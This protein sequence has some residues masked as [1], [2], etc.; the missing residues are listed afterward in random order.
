[1][2]I[3]IN[4]YYTK[5]G[6]NPYDQFEYEL[7]T[8]E[9]KNPDGT[10]VFRQENVEVPK[11]WSQVA[12]DILASKYFK[13]AG[14]PKIEKE[15][16][17]KQV[18]HRL[19][20]TWANW[21]E[22]MGYFTTEEDKQAFYD[23]IVYMLLAQIA[24]PNSPQFFNTGLYD[25]YGIKGQ[26]RGMW[27]VDHKTGK[28]YETDNEFVNP[29]PHACFIL[30]EKDDLLAM[31]E[32]L[33]TETILF[34]A[35]SGVGSNF[36]VWRGKG[37]KISG[38]GKS[39]GLISFLRVRDANAGS[40][41]SGGV[42][43][44][45]AKMVC[46]DDRHP[47]LE[48]FIDWKVKEEEKV[49]ALGK[50]GYDTDFN[51]EAYDTV[52]GQNSNNS[53]RVTNE[54][55]NAVLNDEEWELVGRVDPSVNKKV[56]AQYLWKKI[57]YAGWRCA[58]PALQYH[59]TINEWNT[60][61]NDGEINS[62]N[63]CSEYHFLDDTACNLASINLM[64]FLDTETYEFNLKA[65]LHAI[66]LWQI[67][68]DI[69]VTMAQLPSKEIAIGTYNYRTTGLGYGNLG[70][71]LM[72]LGL[73]Y[74]SDEGRA[75]AGVLTSILTGQAYKT[76][77][78][79]AEVFGG[80]PRFKENESSMRR[81]LHNHRVATYGDLAPVYN[82]E[83][84][85][86][87]IKPMGLNHKLLHKL[88]F[89]HLSETSLKIWDEV[90]QAKK[91]NS[92][93]VTCIAPTGTI[94]LLMDFDTTSI[95]PA[96]SLIAYKKLAGG[97]YMMIPNR[98][99]GLALKHLGYS[100]EQ[101]KE[102]LEFVEQ[103]HNIENAP[104]IKKEHIPIFDTANRNPGGTRFIDPM[105]HVK[106][107]AATSAFLSGSSSK[108]VNLP[109]DATVEDF[110]KVHMEAW[111]LG[112]KCVALYRD[113]CKASQPLN[114]MSDNQNK[115]K[116]FEDMNYDELVKTAYELK[117]KAE[118][119]TRIAPPPIRKA[120]VHEAKV[121]DMGVLVKVGF[122]DDGRIAE[123]Y[124]DTNDS[125]LVKGLLNT[126]SIMASH[127]IQRNIPINDIAKM[128]RKEKYE[129]S[130][131][132]TKHPHIKRVD[133]LGDLIAKV[134]EL[135][136]DNYTKQQTNDD[137]VNIYD[138]EIIKDA[139]ENGKVVYGEKCSTCGSERLRQNGTCKVCLDCGT[140]TG[141]S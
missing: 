47:D 78:E 29:T 128:L 27:R 101:I 102:I 130:G 138:E 61:A 90:V 80:F 2:G 85:K 125:Q 18:V 94:G 38:G 24:A 7:R 15:T 54:F 117:Q 107:L 140:T 56:K 108:T 105:G 9:I 14:V 11:H 103:N 74:D 22:K 99:I 75:L 129:P 83:Y 41:K 69:S 49:V 73:P 86:L 89:K 132:V 113:G 33:K 30:K 119:P 106:M 57:N 5:K 60:C 124:A 109:N 110:E 55:M 127:M 65:Y 115:E 111:K 71:L 50:M 114:V 139:K 44:R 68:L 95:E 36:G 136:A 70:Q 59:T 92:A 1:M 133:S 66:R 45:A 51:G 10:I 82:L 16:S 42:S 64:K 76:S 62:S 13:R 121:G 84:D 137:N 120:V 17:V 26:K 77:A 116:K 118:K 87:S 37:E 97:G 104:H 67:V 40:I 39:S 23:E 31:M 96:F 58:D 135:E 72:T 52:S 122:Y 20:L 131:F 12:T 19:A 48:E 81:V 63:P 134:L 25:A 126:L 32:G 123:V 4:R 79:L 21:G 6:Q 46:V 3:K 28:V 34:R 100:D 53:I 98:S 43:R 93:F 88:G 141:C 91:F 112:V 35:G 8:S